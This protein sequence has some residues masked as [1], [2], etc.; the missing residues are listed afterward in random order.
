[1]VRV[2]IT[3]AH[4][5]LGLA[6]VKEFLTD[7][8]NQVV[9]F[10]GDE[11]QCDQLNTLKEST[12]DKQL[13]I[14]PVK[15]ADEESIKA[16]VEP[17][18]Q[19]IDALDLLIFNQGFIPNDWLD[20]QVDADDISQDRYV[21]YI[22]YKLWYSSKW[23]SSAF[24]SLLE[25]GIN[26]RVI[27]FSL[28]MPRQRD[29]NTLV[30]LERKRLHSKYIRFWFGSFAHDVDPS[31]FGVIDLSY[32]FPDEANLDQDTLD[33]MNI[34]ELV[35]QVAINQKSRA[36]YENIHKLP[37]GKHYVVDRLFA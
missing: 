37:H 16:S 17:I 15:L 30:S 10:C 25:K 19:F 21:S 34:F 14:V 5:G 18:E 12:A 20:Y 22:K 28:C 8:D 31:V 33:R 11:T 3:E 35:D 36:F 6:L 4:E 27:G 23:T 9:A 1:M 32:I 29:S 7:A 24:Y 26:T 2:L 13:L